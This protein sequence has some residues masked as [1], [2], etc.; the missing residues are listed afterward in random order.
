[1][2]TSLFDLFSVGISFD[3]PVFTANRQDKEVRAAVS[4]AE[5]IK[6]ERQLIARRLVAELDTT[7][8]Q[9]QR[10]NERFALYDRQLLPQMAE[11]AEA[12][13]T[14]YNNDDGDFAEAVRSRIAEL[15]A[16]IDALGIAVERL[17]VITHMKYL[18]AG[19]TNA[20]APTVK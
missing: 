9:L 18:L 19:K 20:N 14:A 2:S 8:S 13:L 7:I 11:Q 5:A 10:L 12:S 1:M 3:L 16:K 15:N 17:Q 6:T 4:R